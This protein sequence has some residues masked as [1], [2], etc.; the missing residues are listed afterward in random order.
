MKMY[1]YKCLNIYCDSE[2]RCKILTCTLKMEIY[3]YYYYYYYCYYYV[4]PSDTTKV[5]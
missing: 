4:L 1:S 3:Y 5:Y 2:R